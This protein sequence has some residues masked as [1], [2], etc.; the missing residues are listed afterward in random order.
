MFMQPYAIEFPLRGEWSAPQSP[1]DKVP[2]H[3][4]E[5]FGAR[6]AYDFVKIEWDS[7]IPR[8]YRTSVLEY[9]L[10]GVSLK[11]CYGWGEG[12]YSPFDGIVVSTYGGV[13]ERDPVRI[14]SDL[15]YQNKT[16]N[17]IRKGIINI[18]NI[19]GNYVIIRNNEDIYGLFAHLK[20]NSI[21]V[22]ENE[23]VKAGQKIGLMGH[24]G[25][26]MAPHLHFQLTDS[27]DYTTAKG[28]PCCF[29]ALEYYE[30]GVWTT[31]YNTIP[32]KNDRIRYNG[33]ENP[34]GK[35]R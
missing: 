9:L 26:S 23:R 15:K 14:I 29:K 7:K 33:I 25:N 22:K 1:G 8:F 11:D 3:G 34:I 6:Y 30:N 5:L 10:F 35:H 24:S 4:T 20:H 28:I 31:K 2:S 19:A 27:S 13:K 17:D 18:E 12:I 32:K 21:L 16:N